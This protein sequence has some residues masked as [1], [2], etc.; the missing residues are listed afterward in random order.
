MKHKNEKNITKEKI[1]E[2]K[3]LFHSNITMVKNQLN[4]QTSNIRK[5]VYSTKKE[6]RPPFY[7][8]NI[9][10]FHFLKP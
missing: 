7:F 4:L 5:I 2:R 8:S 6:K 9:S 10:L 1:E 3:N